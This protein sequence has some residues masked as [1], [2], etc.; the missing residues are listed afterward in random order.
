VAWPLLFVG[1]DLG[2]RVVRELLSARSQ[3]LG[4]QR[5]VA[6]ELP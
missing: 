5:L 6:V 2:V 4:A 3:P 1:F